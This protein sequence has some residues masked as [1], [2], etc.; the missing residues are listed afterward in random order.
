M[1]APHHKRPRHWACELV[2]AWVAGQ[3]T[4]QIKARIPATDRELAS[5]H[6][7]IFCLHIQHHAKHTHDLAP[8]GQQMADWVSAY[9]ARRKS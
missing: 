6:A 9:R 4:E 2:D 8:L 1:H 7:R 5:T 3:P